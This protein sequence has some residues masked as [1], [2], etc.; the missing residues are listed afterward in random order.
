MTRATGCCA[1]GDNRAEIPP[2]PP[3][4]C[5]GLWAARSLAQEAGTGG[6]SETLQALIDQGNATPVDAYEHALANAARESAELL[7]TLEDFDAVLTVAAQGV[8]PVGMP[9]G[10]PTFSR[11]WQVLGLPSVTI[12]GNADADGMPL[13][14]QVVG[15]PGGEAALIAV[16]SWVARRLDG[17]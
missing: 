11:P 7:H 8:A 2:G 14:V 12:P 1:P 17:W 13:G 5:D 9:T 4:H 3:C 10:S 6:L 16:A 15:R